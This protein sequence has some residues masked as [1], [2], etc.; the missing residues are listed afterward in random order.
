M[1]FVSVPITKVLCGARETAISHDRWL[2]VV[3]VV[4]YARYE[5]V[6]SVTGICP[7][8]LLAYL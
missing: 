8:P 3:T 2:V 5:Y 6:L 1:G 4:V 7:L